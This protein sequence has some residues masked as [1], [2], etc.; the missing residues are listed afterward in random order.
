MAT[1]WKNHSK[2]LA[3]TQQICEIIL[4]KE[5]NNLRE[6]LIYLYKNDIHNPEK[7]AFRDALYCF[8]A[9]KDGYDQFDHKQ[10]QAVSFHG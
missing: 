1:I 4:N 7:E 8:L 2:N 9:Q 5:F 6:E 3:V 10:Q